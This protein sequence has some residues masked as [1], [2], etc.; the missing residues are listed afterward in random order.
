M[1]PVVIIMQR[2]VLVLLNGALL[3]PRTTP[4]VCDP[5]LFKIHF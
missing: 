5:V 3:S 2:I 1:H 4:D